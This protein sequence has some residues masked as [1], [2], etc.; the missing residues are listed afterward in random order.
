VAE[1]A[2]QQTLAT[3]AGRDADLWKIRFYL[4]RSNAWEQFVNIE[5][6]TDFSP[7]CNI[8]FENATYDMSQGNTVKRQTSESLFNFDCYAVGR[9]AADGT[10]H[11][12][13][14][15]EAALNAHRAARLVR[16][17]IMAG[18]NAYLGLQGTVGRRWPQ[19]LTV[20]QPE[21]EGRSVQ[22]IICARFTLRVHHNEVSPQY[23]GEIMEQINTTIKRASDGQILVNMEFDK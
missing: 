5:E 12:A 15:K 9:S 11:L 22:H 18:E 8:W 14:D 1:I 16:N 19:N 13:G 4:E 3:A 17:I 23:S 21:M 7:I 10:G 20:L 2:N 6:I